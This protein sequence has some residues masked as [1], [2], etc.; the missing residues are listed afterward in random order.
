MSI[1]PM[2]PEKNISR[3]VIN[4]LGEYFIIRKEV[5]G[6]HAITKKGKRIDFIVFPKENLILNNF[7]RIPIGIEIKPSIF[8]DGHKKQVVELYKQS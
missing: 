2:E 3:K 7:P 1:I 4:I 8:E 6:I 5:E